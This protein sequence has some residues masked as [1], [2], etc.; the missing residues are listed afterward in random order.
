MDI[1]SSAPSGAVAL[2]RRVAQARRPGEQCELCGAALAAAHRHL[3]EAATRKIVCACHPCALLFQSTPAARWKL[4][5][6]DAR[7]LEH[8]RLSEAQW[9]SLGVP[10]RLAFFCAS[11]QPGH[12][13]VLY[14]SPGGATQAPLSL[15]DWE[16][17]V[18]DNPVLRTLQ[19]DVEAL[20]VNR[21][22]AAQ[23]Y[24]LA[25]IDRCYELVGLIRLHWRGFSGGDA[26]WKEIDGFFHRLSAAALPQWPAP[27]RVVPD[28]ASVSEQPGAP[29]PLPQELAAAGGARAS[30]ATEVPHA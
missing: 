3:F 9:S 14:P 8:F 15:A 25:P 7:R 28:G 19:P 29:A 22:G 16:G 27:E 12:A 18:A 23:D 26:V 2:L 4:I 17:L 20:L 6:R 11:S 10:I 30:R 21:V 13:S 5:P 1:Q 24:F